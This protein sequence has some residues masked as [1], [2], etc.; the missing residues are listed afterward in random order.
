M[1][2]EALDAVKP[3]PFISKTMLAEAYEALASIA[4]KLKTQNFEAELHSM[5]KQELLNSFL[6][7]QRK[8]FRTLAGLFGEEGVSLYIDNYKDANQYKMQ[9]YI[10]RIVQFL[11]APAKSEVVQLR[12]F[13]IETLLSL[14]A[15]AQRAVSLD[16][17]MSAL[18]AMMQTSY[19]IQKTAG[20]DFVTPL[21]EERVQVAV[22][23][24]TSSKASLQFWVAEVKNSEDF[25]RNYLQHVQKALSDPFE[26]ALVQRL[27]THIETSVDP[28]AALLYWQRVS[29]PMNT[30]YAQ[31]VENKDP[32]LLQAAVDRLSAY[33]EVHKN[34][35][36]A[37]DLLSRAD[38]ASNYREALIESWFLLYPRSALSYYADW[39]QK[40]IEQGHVVPGE[41]RQ[42]TLLL[43][44][45]P[46]KTVPL[47][48]VQEL[49][50]THL[51]ATLFWLKWYLSSED[52]TVPNIVLRLDA[53]LYY[54]H[55]IPESTQLELGLQ[56]HTVKKIDELVSKSAIAN[57][58]KN[59]LHR[60]FMQCVRETDQGSDI[61]SLLIKAKMLLQ[62]AEAAPAAPNKAA[63]QTSQMNNV[64]M[65]MQQKTLHLS[66]ETSIRL[67]QEM[68]REDASLFEK[69]SIQPEGAR[70]W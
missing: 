56:K 13:F 48:N 23:K 20:G 7:Y 11:E 62:K 51:T 37:L 6:A 28:D 50:R 70:P 9:L 4:E 38:R 59:E 58:L 21:L 25:A 22:E 67:L 32:H 60:I 35:A 5:S 36:R 18:Y 65:Q 44:K 43:E 16:S 3:S 52:A 42:F 14:E 26:A 8:A 68:E 12:D 2:K 17:L 69:K 61:S 10:D 46:P 53:A 39:L 54:Q 24:R 30:L 40:Q 31:L 29:S 49:L 41:M 47:S 55:L 19:L 27:I 1:A 45:L 57:P 15:S 34:V 63:L 64:T 66:G 33:Q